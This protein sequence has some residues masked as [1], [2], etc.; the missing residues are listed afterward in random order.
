ML[1]V[2][3]YYWLTVVCLVIVMLLAV[4]DLGTSGLVLVVRV[5]RSL[6]GLC[7]RWLC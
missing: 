5:G 4:L 3:C 7:L 2:S 6:I 1:V